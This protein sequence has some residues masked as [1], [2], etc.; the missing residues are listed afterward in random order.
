VLAVCTVSFLSSLRTHGRYAIVQEMYI[1]P[2][3]RSTGIGTSV[4]R[5]ALDHAVAAG[6]RLV[7]LGTTVPGQR[8]IQ[9]YERAGFRQ[10]GARLRWTLASP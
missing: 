6:C 4:L 1:E 3:V 7:E 8:Q 9:F 5:F 2:E 10:V